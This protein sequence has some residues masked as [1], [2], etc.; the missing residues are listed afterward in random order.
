MISLLSGCASMIAEGLARDLQQG[1]ANQ[2][3]PAIVRAGAP[4]YMLLIDGNIQ[5]NPDERGL[6]LAGARLYSTYA[7]VFVKDTQ[8]AK[9][10]TSRAR[11]YA[12]RAICLGQ[13]ELCKAKQT[14]FDKFVAVINKMTKSDI[15]ALYIYA[16][17]WAGW[18]L[19]NKDDWNA[20]ADLPKIEAMM[21]RVVMLDDGYQAGLAHVYLGV[22]KT[23]LPANLGGKPEQGKLHFER[24][25]KLSKGRNLIAKVEFAKRYARLVFDR[26]LHDSL[27]NDVMSA[28]PQYPGLTLSNVL[29]QQQARQLLDTAGDYF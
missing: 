24:A 13:G 15:D 4:A 5:N 12:Q 14:S 8:R 6:L 28:T 18:V 1:I 22:L 3:D 16:T 21:E 20:V 25:I 10:L 11:D 7:S 2:D 19:A 27:L 29:A 26:K 9:L 23:R 17:A